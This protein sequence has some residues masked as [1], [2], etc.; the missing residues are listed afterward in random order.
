MAPGRDRQPPLISGV[1]DPAIEGVQSP[2]FNEAGDPDSIQQVQYAAGSL[3]CVGQCAE[4]W[5]DGKA[6]AARDPA[7]VLRGT[8]LRFASEPD[9]IS[10]MADLSGQWPLFYAPDGELLRYSSDAQAL[11]EIVGTKVDPLALGLFII[12]GEFIDPGK[13]VFSKVDRLPAGHMLRA[14]HHGQAVAEYAT[15]EPDHSVRLAETAEDLREHLIQAVTFWPDNDADQFYSFSGGFDSTSLAFLRASMLPPSASLQ[16]FHTQRIA[17]LSGDT[18]YATSYA[19]LNPQIDLSHIVVPD[20]ILP[21]NDLSAADTQYPFSQAEGVVKQTVD[22]ELGRIAGLGAKVQITGEGG[23]ALF[24]T[25]PQYLADVMTHPVRNVLRL[26]NE[27]T[28]L[29]HE[30]EVAFT[31]LMKAM[32]AHT[33][34]TYAGAL[35]SIAAAIDRGQDSGQ[36]TWH[37]ITA[38]AIPLLSDP[39]RHQVA[40]LTFAKS[41]QAAQKPT[42]GIADFVALNDL[43][44]SGRFTANLRRSADQFGIATRA[45]FLDDPVIA[46]R[47]RLQT[48]LTAD[49]QQFKALLRASLGEDVPAPV[50]DRTGKGS[51]SREAYEG[52]RANAQVLR[53][54]FGSDSYLADLGVINPAAFQ[55]LIAKAEMGQSVPL[56][57]LERA[58][59]AELWLRQHYGG[60]IPE[61]SQSSSSQSAELVESAPVVPDES[62]P[63]VIQVP[64]HIRMAETEVGIVAFNLKTSV[65][66]NLHAKAALVVK[67]LQ[68]NGSV[69]DAAAALRRQFPAVESE[70]L[71]R[72]LTEIVTNLLQQG[73]I[74]AGTFETFSIHPAARRTN[75]AAGEVRL[76]RGDIDTTGV[77]W[78]DYLRMGRALLQAMRLDKHHNLYDKL[79]VIAARKRNLPDADVESIRRHLVAGHVLARF[80]LFR[81]IVCSDLASATV[82]AEAMQGRSAEYI[83]AMV[84]DPNYYHAAP[85]VNGRPV[86]TPQDRIMDDNF[87]TLG[88]F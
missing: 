68:S 32:R 17:S 7:T 44:L 46:A 38:D 20:E 65:V 24:A 4:P 67:A 75:D 5:L 3:A 36:L 9:G 2:V 27:G 43:R 16:A 83:L 80:S 19:A 22:Y 23:D 21:Y 51:Y 62:L 79:Q 48:H 70:L 29:A 40:E 84:P 31:G 35:R 61:A 13:T 81:S 56:D 88:I 33:G 11:A 25:P 54:L 78:R 77:R 26:A 15:L 8:S 69:T 45:P 41:Q 82:L 72:D 73:T 63:Q 39:M 64:D 6:E 85:G 60:S 18:A 42:V 66:H 12:G 28:V 57:A 87:T 58:V 76:I 10:A 59:S 74:E 86:Q 53:A 49:H 55:Q 71:S 52:I 1:F 50:F 14:D 47:F 37:R 34:F 30:G